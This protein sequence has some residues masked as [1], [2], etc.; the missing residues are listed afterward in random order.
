MKFPLACSHPRFNA[1]SAVLWASI[2]ILI[3]WSEELIRVS[4][5]TS[6]YARVGT[7]PDCLLMSISYLNLHQLW[8]FPI[9]TLLALFCCSGVNSP[10][11]ILVS[12][13]TMIPKLSRSQQY[14]RVALENRNQISFPNHWNAF[15]VS[16]FH[17]SPHQASGIS[18]SSLLEALSLAV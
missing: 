2:S 12:L 18:S 3:T 9:Q 7:Y 16:H 6:L 4:T 5:V 13:L 1:S 14:C 10:Q 15:P 17:L 11:F 8:E